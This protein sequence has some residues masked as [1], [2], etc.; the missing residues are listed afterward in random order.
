MLP[1]KDLE[2]LAKDNC[3]IVR[4]LACKKLLS[5]EAKLTNKADD[6]LGIGSNAPCN[7]DELSDDDSVQALV[8]SACTGTT[9]SPGR[10]LLFTLTQC[11][12]NVLAKNFRSRSWLERFAIAGNPSTP[13]AVLER[14]A[15]D[16]NQLVRRA[17]TA[18]LAARYKAQSGA[19][20]GG[21][22]QA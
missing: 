15:N 3:D 20:G 10:R 18:N 8:A 6:L 2:R 22:D 12:A 4:K 7:N 16:G 14:M 1:R 11:P 19:D 9:P 17:A 13:E 21:S 5:L